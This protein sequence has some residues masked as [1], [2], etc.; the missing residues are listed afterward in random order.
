MSGDDDSHAATLFAPPPPSM[1]REGTA[2]AVTLA[3]RYEVLALLGVGGM[4][5]VYRARDLELDELV[6]L[7]MLRRELSKHDVLT[8]EA[9][10][11]ML[12]SPQGE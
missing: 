2:G 6:A 8:S 10:I 5:A 4:G 11:A 12:S 9:R 7:K 3:G 1:V